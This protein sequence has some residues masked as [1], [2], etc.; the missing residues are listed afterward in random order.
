MLNFFDP[1]FQEKPLKHLQFGLCDNEDGAVAF[2][3]TINK[4]KWTASVENPNGLTLIFTAIDKGVIKDNEYSGYERCDGMLTSDYH[5][6]FVELKNER[7]GW[8]Q[9]GISQLESTIKLFNN[10]HPGAEKRYTHKKAYICNKKHPCF[11][12]INNEQNLKFFKLCHFRLD[13]QSEILLAV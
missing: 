5:L 6:C 1:S 4:E 7:G 2:T 11:H 9:K 13:I 10:A 12:V 8:I 3:D